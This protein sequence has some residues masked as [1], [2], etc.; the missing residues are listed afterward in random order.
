MRMCQTSGQCILIT[1]ARPYLR[2]AL[3]LG[4]SSI[5][6]IHYYR[7]GYEAFLFSIEILA[8][9]FVVIV[10]IPHILIFLWIFY[11]LVH[12]LNSHCGHHFNTMLTMLRR[13]ALPLHKGHDYQE[14]CD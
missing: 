12:Y 10:V 1:S 6:Y 3:R 5:D 2:L 14:L 4:S 7:A 11:K 9:M 13:G 8:V